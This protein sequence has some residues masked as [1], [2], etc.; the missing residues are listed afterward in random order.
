MR[1]EILGEAVFDMRAGKFVEFE[2]V[3]LGQRWGRTAFNGRIEQLEPSPIGY[4]VQLAH[5]DAPLVAPALIPEYDA[6]W[7]RRPN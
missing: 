6:E 2:F 3:A 5:S 1:T 7:V 4:V